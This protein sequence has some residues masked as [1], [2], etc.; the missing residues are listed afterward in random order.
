MLNPGHFS[1]KTSPLSV[2]LALSMTFHAA[3]VS[4]FPEPRPINPA[5]FV[6]S[7]AF[8]GEALVPLLRHFVANT[9]QRWRTF[10]EESRFFRHERRRRSTTP[11]ELDAFFSSNEGCLVSNDPVP[12]G[13]R[14]NPIFRGLNITVLEGVPHEA[15]TYAGNYL[16]AL[17][18]NSN[19]I[20]TFDINN[21]N[22]DAL[23]EAQVYI[24]PAGDPRVQTMLE[25]LARVRNVPINVLTY[26]NQRMLDEEQNASG[27]SMK[28]NLS[29][30]GSRGE[31]NRVNL[32]LGEHK[33]QLD[34]T[35][36][37]E[38]MLYYTHAAAA[39]ASHM[40]INS[41]NDPFAN[42]FVVSEMGDD[43]SVRWLPDETFV[44]NPPYDSV[45]ANH[46]VVRIPTG[47]RVLKIAP[48]P[49][50]PEIAAGLAMAKF[51]ND[52][53]N[54]TNVIHGSGHAGYEDTR[55]IQWR[56]FWYF[57]S[58]HPWD[59]PELLLRLA[60]GRMRRDD[61]DKVA[62]AWKFAV[63]NQKIDLRK[64]EA[65]SAA[66]VL[67]ESF[68]NHDAHI[69]VRYLKLDLLHTVGREDDAYQAA[70]KTY[71]EV[72]DDHLKHAPD[73][74]FL[75]FLPH[76]N[77][78]H[79]SHVRATDLAN[80]VLAQ[81]KRENPKTRFL[82]A[83][84]MAPWAGGTNTFFH[85]PENVVTDHSLHTMA[86]RG[87][88]GLAFLT[89][90]LTA[91]FGGRSHPPE[92]MGGPFAER[93][94]RFRVLPPDDQFPAPALETSPKAPPKKS[95]YPDFFVDCM[96][97]PELAL[98]MFLAL[99]VL[100]PMCASGQTLRRISNVASEGVPSNRVM[101]FLQHDWQ[102]LIDVIPYRIE[103]SRH[104]GSIQYDANTEGVIQNTQRAAEALSPATGK[105]AE[106][107][108][109][110]IRHLIDCRT[111]SSTDLLKQWEEFIQRVLIPNGL[112]GFLTPST[113]GKR[114]SLITPIYVVQK[115]PKGLPQSFEV[116]GESFEFVYLKKRPGLEKLGGVNLGGAWRYPG[117]RQASVFLD[118]IEELTQRTNRAI[119]GGNFFD[120]TAPGLSPTMKA[121]ASSAGFYF[122]IGKNRTKK[123]PKE[124]IEDVLQLFL[125]GEQIAAWVEVGQ[126]PNSLLWKDPLQEE[127][128]LSPDME[129]AAMLAV[130]EALTAV[131]ARLAIA[132]NPA[133]ILLTLGK[134]VVSAGDF[135]NT[136]GTIR[137]RASSAALNLM[138][139]NPHW[140]DGKNGREV[141]EAVAALLDKGTS[142]IHQS[143][144]ELLLR[145]YPDLANFWAPLTEFRDKQKQGHTEDLCRAA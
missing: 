130:K 123:T 103:A 5:S 107:V 105:M 48:H 117:K 67:K 53:V 108:V 7:D 88:R 138:L 36:Y 6:A 95:K 102:R 114:F 63:R 78:A 70:Y 79:G 89:T 13:I 55:T 84:Y 72:L 122:S 35:R 56:A 10:R 99:V 32:A 120:L 77:D 125:I 81:L 139:A 64:P 4:T 121:F 12:A 61:E 69:D 25:T 43:G 119:R 94:T 26:P 143:A 19:T 42:N 111:G 8:A 54:I 97:L 127:K 23:N 91:F 113:E 39:Q 118:E 133:P 14:H 71:K 137:A 112:Y 57:A 47:A 44:V 136:K 18:Q 68:A 2:L 82:M 85:S 98:S 131:L 45:G 51:L 145:G 49:D 3:T 28:F 126:D 59:V 140:L 11:R 90:E 21:V 96:R 100:L 33:S 124:K 20:N 129:P 17:R 142:C 22:I 9:T 31:F 116:N 80:R 135:P 65:E 62:W 134:E 30:G 93:F 15:D 40:G 141:G 58:Y 46:T 41:N 109:D 86:E 128:W 60:T 73:S 66:S 52:G 144:F 50:D 24:V 87:K 104:H 37:D 76:P 27:P 110:G 106:A 115:A 83:H 38:M 101:Y 75:V 132:K 1:F 16:S 92:K 29:I 74:P 34:R